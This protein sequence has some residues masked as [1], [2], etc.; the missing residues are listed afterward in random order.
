MS[1]LIF[2]SRIMWGLFQS[3]PPKCL[4]VSVSDWS[5]GKVDTFRTPSA[6]TLAHLFL[7]FLLS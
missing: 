1:V 3:I 7:L 5:A 2:T 4:R 6:S